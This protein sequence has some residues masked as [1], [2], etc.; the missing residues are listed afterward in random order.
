[1]AYTATVAKEKI[2]QTSP[3]EYNVSISVVIM[4][5]ATEK[6]N[7]VYSKRYTQGQTMASV[8]AALIKLVQADWAKLL[9]EQNLYNAAAFGTMCSEMQTAITGYLNP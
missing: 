5:G 6:L 9:A 1:M 8:K 7:K 4:D 2:E 3:T